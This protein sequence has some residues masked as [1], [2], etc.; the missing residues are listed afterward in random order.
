MKEVTKEAFINVQES[1]DQ[2]GR[3]T[4]QTAGTNPVFF[5]DRIHKYNRTEE[6]T[7]TDQKGCNTRPALLV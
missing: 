7:K 4:N 2:T 5:L 3:G 6:N 1:A